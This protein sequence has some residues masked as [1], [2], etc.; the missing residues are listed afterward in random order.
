MG[1]VLANV[2]ERVGYKVTREYY[3]NDAGNQIKLLGESILAALGKAEPKE[4]HYKGD[5]IKTLAESL[6]SKIPASPA[7]RQISNSKNLDAEAVGRL[8]ANNLL[9]G[10]KKSV[11]EV[12]IKFDGWFSEYQNLYKKGELKKVLAFLEKNGF[13]SEREGAKWLADHVLVKSDGQPTYFLA[14]LAYH[15]DKFIKRKFDCAIDIWGADHHGYIDRL[16]TGV[17]ALGIDP[18]KLKILITQLVRL[19]ENGKEVRM[20]KRAGEF[21]TLDEL[22]KE[23]GKDAARFFFLMHSPETHMDF[24]L[25]LAK[26]KSA[27]NPVY[28]AQ[29]A[30]VRCN[31]ILKK[32]KSKRIMNYELGIKNLETESELNLLKELV[33]L[34]DVIQQ[35]AEDYQVSRLARYSLEVARALNNFYEKERVIDQSGN[36]SEARLALVS[37]TRRIL[38]EAFDVLGIEKPIKM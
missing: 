8:A 22:I 1:D 11:K 38:G 37:A 30:Y 36:V 24:D 21:V 19:V 9:K 27:K 3:V 4:E 13:V 23:V 34:P 7:G 2:L 32:A 12:G 26:E 31:S 18:G 5:Y 20:S 28:Y 15:Y 10:I 35:T 14:D 6:K 33:K 17:G 16:K 25:A 29:Y